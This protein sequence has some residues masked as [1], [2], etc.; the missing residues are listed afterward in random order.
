MFLYV[1]GYKA[2]RNMS[3]F[4]CWIVIAL[5]HFA[6]YLNIRDIQT[7]AFMTKGA[8]TGLRNTILLLV[9]FQVLRVVSLKIQHQELI[10]PSRGGGLDLY[11]EREATFLDLLLFFIYLGAVFAPIAWN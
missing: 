11:N 5:I 8:N 4:I 3:F 9:L 6:I 10:T 7:T 1:F 2:L